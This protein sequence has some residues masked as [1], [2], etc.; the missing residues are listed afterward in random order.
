MKVKQIISYLIIL[1][2]IILAVT[3]AASNAN[4]VTLHYYFGAINISL[5]LLLV[6]ALGIGIILGFVAMFFPYLKLKNEKRTLKNRIKQ[7]EKEFNVP[8]KSNTP[9]V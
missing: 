1:I 6:Y 7:I 2:I 3:F 5:S 8:P 4:T 9:N